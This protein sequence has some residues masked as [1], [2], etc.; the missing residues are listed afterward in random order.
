MDENKEICIL[1]R[2]GLGNQLFGL[3][4]GL[5]LA[6]QSGRKLVLI[7]NDIDK[8]RS[9]GK[10]DITS[11]KLPLAVTTR[12]I[13]KFE[14]LMVRVL[15]KVRNQFPF[16]ETPMNSSLG[17]IFDEGQDEIENKLSSK[18][19][20]NKSKLFLDGYFQYTEF[21]ERASKDIQSLELTNESQW[22]QTLKKQIEIEN[23]SMIHL[24]LGDYL[25][26]L[27]A[28]GVLNTRYYSDA[29]SRL[30]INAGDKIWVFSDDIHSAAEILQGI[31][32]FGF[33]YITSPSNSDPAESLLLMSQAK[34]LIISNSTFSFWSGLMN[35]KDGNTVA[36]RKFYRGST[37]NPFT[38]PKN[39]ILE[40]P[41]WLESKV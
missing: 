9:N 8:S 40:E 20:K 13:G 36:P 32:N 17:F 11:F 5:H 1:L 28:I 35:T 14:Y 6:E 26:N 12:N 7:L 4:S 23:P 15:R 25:K 27:E 22:F 37:S 30:D 39:W 41:Q 18:S 10:F 19:F 38:T 29:I 34:N 16:L 33:E 24:R 3:F 31:A 21:F 2:G